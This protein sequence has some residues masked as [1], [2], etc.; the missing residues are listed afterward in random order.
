MNEKLK[1]FNPDNIK[2]KLVVFRNPTS[3]LFVDMT[4][5]GHKFKLK[6]MDQVIIPETLAIW[7]IG[8]YR[9]PFWPT[10]A[11]IK[12]IYSRNMYRDIFCVVTGSAPEDSKPVIEEVVDNPQ[13]K[14]NDLAKNPQKVVVDMSH[15]EKHD[16][17]RIGGPNF[18]I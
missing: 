6:S 11:E 8:D 9:S 12:A 2:G 4:P 5:R 1:K 10:Q 3:S 13:D 16:S 14:L 17:D 18:T 15:M 7:F